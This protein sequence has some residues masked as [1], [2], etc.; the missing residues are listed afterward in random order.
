MP[1]S[2]TTKIDK[3]FKFVSGKGYTTTQK[4][5]DNEDAPSGFLVGTSS[6]FAQDAGIPS[7]APGASTSILTYYDDGT[8][9]GRYALTKDISSPTNRAWYA[10]SDGSS[11]TQMRAT[12]QGNWVPPTF[13][14]YT[15]RIFLTK[16]SSTTAAYLQ[17]IF[18]S[19]AT[20]P[21]FDYKSGILTFESDPLAAYASVAGGPPDGI[22]I[23]GYR[24]T[25]PLLSQIFDGNGNYTGGL[26]DFSTSTS[27][28]KFL[29][30]SKIF[31]ISSPHATGSTWVEETTPYNSTDVWSAIAQFSNGIIV[32]GGSDS[33]S[34][35]PKITYSYG[36]GEW[37]Q[38]TLPNINGTG[39]IVS[40]CALPDGYV[41]AVNA[42]HVIRSADYGRTWST[43]TGSL[44]TNSFI[45]GSDVTDL[46][47]VGQGGLIHHSSNGTTFSAQT[48]ADINDLYAVW[49]SSSTDIYAVGADGTIRHSTGTGTWSGQTSGTANWLFG[50]FGLSATKVY[51][52]G[53]GGTVLFSTGNGTWSNFNSG[54][55]SSLTCYDV[56][57]H[58]DG[59]VT[60]LYVAGHN[61][62]TNDIEIYSSD[63]TNNWVLDDSF[64]LNNYVKI[65]GGLSGVFASCGQNTIL[66][67]HKNPVLAVHGHSAVDGYLSAAGLFAINLGATTIDVSSTAS[68][69]A[70]PTTSAL[71][72]SGSGASNF[73]ILT[74]SSSDRGEGIRLWRES[75]SIYTLDLGSKVTNNNDGT[76]PVAV[77]G[78]IRLGG[79]TTS[80]STTARAEIET[81][82][83]LGLLVAAYQGDLTIQDSY[84]LAGSR[85][86]NVNITASNGK[87][88]LT[89]NGSNSP[90]GAGQIVLTPGTE[91]YVMVQ[92]NT[93]ATSFRVQSPGGN[94]NIMYGN[95]SFANNGGITT[96]SLNAGSGSIS[97][98]GSMSA[99]SLNITSSISTSSL[100]AS[101]VSTTSLSVSGTTTASV[102]S[103]SGVIVSTNS[104]RT[105]IFY[106]STNSQT[107]VFTLQAY[108]IGGAFLEIGFIWPARFLS[109]PTAFIISFISSLNGTGNYGVTNVNTIGGTFYFQANV[110]GMTGFRV[111]VTASY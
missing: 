43:V 28:A 35:N 62:S 27:I 11:L 39:L 3:A 106:C 76:T 38:A 51:T 109:T 6:I 104:I 61:S 50:V 24:Y 44:G 111:S 93:T 88:N 82:S 107:V 23:S 29:A 33:G 78:R 15:I 60:K 4:G 36:N 37:E 10:S 80:P 71:S 73:T 70:S 86:G 74:Q 48:N 8:V 64:T 110:S 84:G 89:A 95:G 31:D 22:Q 19:D 59:G 49:G 53:D 77:G 103:A 92:S 81:V 21:M 105:P 56:W 94:F 108:C 9:I 1:I 25:G 91:A 54:I 57:G 40:L 85:L 79:F 32:A 100:S 13:G 68:F 16:T 52:C 47:M 87:V 17:E 18:F 45:W 30:S 102:I 58:S 34:L 66:A 2:D 26:S 96:T 97:T 65:A 99:N 7:T 72:V 12:R 67:L 41:Y 83:S 63:G 55:P 98:T 90:T 14:N 42:T 20:S 5:V 101:S 46:F 75:Q 69:T